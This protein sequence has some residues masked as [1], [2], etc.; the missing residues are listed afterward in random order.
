MNFRYFLFILALLFFINNFVM[1]MDNTFKIRGTLPWHNFLSGPTSWNERDYKE[2][3]NRMQELDL[4]LIAFHC[5]T[6]GAERYVNYVEPMIKI[7][8]RNVLPEAGFDTGITA[9]WGYRPLMLRDYAF[10]T[11][12]LFPGGDKYFG[13]DCAINAI[14]NE[15]RYEKAQSLM[16]RVMEMAHEKNI[17]FAMGFEFGVYPPEF[18]SITP[19]GYNISGTLLPDPTHPSSIEILRLTID[20]LLEAYPKIDYIWLWLHEHTGFVGKAKLKGKF[21]SLYNVNKQYFAQSGNKD[22]VFTGIWALEFIK[23][24]HH[25]ISKKAPEVRIV[26]SG[27]GGG[28]QLPIVLTGLDQ[29]LPNDI[30]FSCLNPN[31]G[32]APQIEILT[33][34]SKN[35]EVW[36]IPWLE[37]DEKLWH[38][39]PRVTLMRDQVQLAYKQNLDGVLA[40]HWRTKETELNLSAF[41]KFAH[42][43]QNSPAV[44]SIYQEY[45][46]KNFGKKAADVL[47][48]DLVSMDTEQWLNEPNSPVYFPYNPKWG[49]ITPKLQAKLDVLMQKFE[50]VY[51]SESDK[52][53]K[54]NLYWWISNL[55]FTLLL[56]EIGR[57]IEPIYN[58]KEAWILG[59]E[60]KKFSTREIKELKMEFYEAPLEEL[61]DTFRDRRLTRGELGVLSSVN[62]RLWLQYKDLYDFLD[63][64]SGEK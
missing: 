57:K 64:I 18:A 42:D 34:I 28:N 2:Y 47:I 23:Q 58:L 14:S 62:Q 54:E 32:W 17:K 4:N 9:R 11:G 6:G 61:F 33:D 24:A 16:R 19:R 52:I 20:D 26:I 37:G 12:K 51:Q 36:G 8:Y 50:S 38:M 56:D 15:D 35:R 25:Y 29:A 39:Q 31:Q 46:E 59:E 13:A 55:R 43:P 60:G 27:W 53:H 3:L 63:N 21:L 49:R 40:I 1:S 30:I 41:S 5:Y 44:E 48:S 10:E 45:C 22:A 7:R